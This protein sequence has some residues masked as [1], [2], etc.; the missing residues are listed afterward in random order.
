MAY[1][2]DPVSEWF[3]EGARRLLARAYA[4]PGDWQSTRLANPGP[5]QL[6]RLAALGVNPFAADRPSTKGGTGLDARTRW[7]RAFVRALYYQ[8]RW[9]SG[10]PGGGW[11]RGRRNTPRTTGALEVR[12]GRMLPVRGIIPA[13]RQVRVRLVRAGPATRK[14]YVDRLP[15]SRRTY[16]DQEAP[17]SRWSDPAR[18][19]W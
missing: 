17:G 8:H 2:R 6:A 4:H 12:V 14:A 5:A 3:D 15:A 9:Y 10:R 11:R 13:G 1:S 18:R 16:D 7:C 19:D